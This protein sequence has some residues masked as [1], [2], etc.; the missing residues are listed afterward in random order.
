MKWILAIRLKT[1]TASISSVIL[2]S[3]LAFYDFYLFKIIPFIL[4]F[5]YAIIMQIISNYINDYADG[6]KGIDGKGRIGPVRVIAT[7]LMSTDE[8]LF[9]IY[10]MII[11][12]FIIGFPLIFYGGIK[13]IILGVICLIG[14]YVY[15][16]GPFPMSFKGLGDINVI[17]FYGFISVIGTYYLQTGYFNKNV[18]YLG[19]ASGMLSNNILIINNIRDQSQDK[20]FNK[21]TLIVRFGKKFGLYHYIIN[22]LVSFL[23]PIMIIPSYNILIIWLLLPFALWTCVTLHYTNKGYEYNLLLFKSSMIV[24][25]YTLLFLIVILYQKCINF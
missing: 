11:I 13:L 20:K 18:F 15:S 1:L 5:I 7:G 2:G 8:I 22:I 10:F 24:F 9:A 12:S 16:L 14:A 6:L 19:L 23:I 17:I 3:A 4:C 21:K 25:I